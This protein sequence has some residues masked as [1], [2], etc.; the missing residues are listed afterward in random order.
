MKKNIKFLAVALVLILSVSLILMSCTSKKNNY[1]DINNTALTDTMTNLFVQ[2]GRLVEKTEDGKTKKEFL[3]FPMHSFNYKTDKVEIRFNNNFKAPTPEELKYDK[4]IDRI[5]EIKNVAQAA[6]KNLNTVESVKKYFSYQN[7]FDKTPMQALLMR[8]A[9]SEKADFV[10]VKTD[11][12]G[13][14]T[15][16]RYYEKEGK[17][18]FTL[19]AEFKGNYDVQQKNESDYEIDMEI[20]VTN[21]AKLLIE[22]L[23]DTL[24]KF[25]FAYSLDNDNLAAFL[26][27]Y[28]NEALKDVKS[29][30]AEIVEPVKN[31]KNTKITVKGSVDG[32]NFDKEI[33]SL[34]FTAEKNTNDNK[35]SYT[36]KA[37]SNFEITIYVD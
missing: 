29:A 21:V 32:K 33:V 12:S 36:L 8:L 3:P 18:Y 2:D 6:E 5:N 30:K 1:K 22:N 27:I 4:Q 9:A 19:E 25:N 16:I 11:N 13:K 28:G 14:K 10:I 7:K 20:K 37:E 23:S 17:Q 35:T 15:I 34:D 24:I 31:E 26:N